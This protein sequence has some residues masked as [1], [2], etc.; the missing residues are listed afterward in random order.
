MIKTA[1]VALTV[2]GCDCDAKLCE[3]IT[4]TTARWTTIEECEA[5]MTAQILRQG[6]YDYPLISGVC[7]T[8][9]ASDAQMV[10]AASDGWNL[11]AG[12][13]SVSGFAS[14]SISTI[15]RPALYDGVLEGTRTVF[16]KAGDGYHLVRSG[17]DGAADATMDLLRKSAS[18]VLPRG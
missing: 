1:I 13:A 14:A 6:E 10:A 2:V 4:E 18:L 7:R 3:Y 12:P 15:E 11:A 5:A 8:V 9:P 16:R 17:L